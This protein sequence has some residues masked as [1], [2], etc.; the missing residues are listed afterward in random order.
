[1]EAGGF[2]NGQW[3]RNLTKYVE[4]VNRENAK[5][6]RNRTREPVE[7]ADSSKSHHP[8]VSAQQELLCFAFNT[9]D[10]ECTAKGGSVT[11][12]EDTVYSRPDLVAL[13]LDGTNIICKKD[14]GFACTLTFKLKTTEATVMTLKNNSTIEAKGIFIDSPTT[15]LTIQDGS[16]LSADGRSEG[17]LGYYQ[18]QGASYVGQGGYC[19]LDGKPHVEKHYADFDIR[20]NFNNIQDMKEGLLVG[21]IGEYNPLDVRTAGGG[22]IHINV[23]ALDLLGEQAYGHISANGLPEEGTDDRVSVNLNG[24]SGG[25]IYINTKN[26]WSQNTIESTA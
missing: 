26:K 3:P 8:Q 1:M 11:F 16:R 2:G 6:P 22:H 12:T 15:H 9:K 23:D 19:P 13:Y 18:N 14:D 24:G 5:Y 17:F 20:P 25:Y 21:S 4:D 10:G 7:D